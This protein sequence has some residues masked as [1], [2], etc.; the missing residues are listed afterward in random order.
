MNFDDIKEAIRTLFNFSIAGET[1]D[2]I[3]FNIISD[4]IAILDKTQINQIIQDLTSLD[5]DQDVE[6]FD[7]ISYEV[8]VRQENRMMDAR[9]IVQKDIVNKI[10]YKIDKP[11]D[12]YLVFFLFNLGKQ[13][14]PRILRGGI[15]PHRLHRLYNN[16]KEQQ[17]SLFELNVLE[18]IKDI[19]PRLE[20]LQIKSDNTRKKSEFEQ[21]VYAFLFNLGYNLDYTILPLRFMDEFTQPYR[22]G[23]LRRA[24]FSDV[25]PPK[26]IYLNELILHYQKGISSESIDHQFL[27]FYHVL[28][29]FFE[30]IYNDDILNSIKKELTKPSFSYKRNKDLSGLIS[31]IQNRLKYKNDEF[32]LNEPEALELTLRKFVKDILYLSNELTTIS[33]TLIEYFKTTDV[34]F[35]KG[36]K[37]NFENTNVNEIYTNL[38]KRIYLTRNS[39]VHSKETDKSKYT[40][41]RD[42]KDLLTEIYLLRLIAEIV[43]I[44][45]SKEL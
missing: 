9:E 24:N 37:V 5:T 45:N 29:H 16:D 13:N 10:E 38:A 33:P 30:K 20:T 25:E 42:D 28:E 2:K 8:L 32:L 17:T 23:R 15:M 6:L 11:T 7:N 36:N 31:I 26:R 43:I 3:T 21:L 14:T 4:K 35:S 41:F 40:P 39:I 27:S 34:P 1:E 18:V 19:V 22:L 12:K 44:E